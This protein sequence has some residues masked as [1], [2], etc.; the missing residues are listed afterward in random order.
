VE[1]DKAIKIGL[2][3]VI[4]FGI[5]YWGFNFLKGKNIFTKEYTYYAVYERIDGL[6]KNSTIYLRG[7]KVGQVTDIQFTS[8]NYES[9]TLTFAIDKSVQIPANTIARIFSSDIMGTK[10]IDL[11]IPHFVQS[12]NVEILKDKSMLIPDIEGSLTDQ[13]RLEMAPLKKQIE[14]LMESTGTA[15]EQLKFVLNEKTGESLRTS[16]EKIQNAVDAMQ[17]SSVTIDT[18]LTNANQNIQKLLT[19]IESITKNISTKN[20]EIDN[21][22]NNFS[23]ISDTLA[24]ANIAQTIYKT[25][26]VMTELSVM[27]DKV[28]KGEGTLGAIMQNQNLYNNL[29]STSKQLDNLI[30]DIQKNPKR[31]VS[32]PIMNINK[33]E[34]TEQ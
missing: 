13:V 23:S 4:M 3:L 34:K 5:L 14:K 27:L 31:Y 15:I 7:H 21:I 18:I 20:K 32:F 17:H 10:S 19:N 2:L 12:Q 25:E 22:I 11:I 9:I 6:Q 28:N 26:S 30:R 1:K 24:K 33:K 16:F 29:E 8:K